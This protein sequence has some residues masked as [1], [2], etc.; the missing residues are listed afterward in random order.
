MSAFFPWTLCQH[1]WPIM[2]TCEPGGLKA[3][4]GRHHMLKTTI[5]K[6]ILMG[7]VK[8]FWSKF[9]IELR[10]LCD[11]VSLFS[12]HLTNFLFT[13]NW[14]G[15]HYF[16]KGHIFGPR[17]L[18]RGACHSQC[19]LTLYA[20]DLICYFL[21]VLHDIIQQD[22]HLFM[23]PKNKRDLCS[24]IAFKITFF[25][26]LHNGNEIVAHLLNE[27]FTS[28]MMSCPQWGFYVNVNFTQIMRA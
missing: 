15:Y 6:W 5:W 26:Q 28:Y 21:C 18:R 13:F 4:K 2:Y 7:K 20:I 12:R 27:S 19:S 24:N 16:K 9:V 1:V 11:F 14:S 22:Y 23:N 8:D 3:L 10:Q 25:S 17:S